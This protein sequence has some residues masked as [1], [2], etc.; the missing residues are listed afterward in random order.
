M[1]KTSV[2]IVN[3]SHLSIIPQQLEQSLFS[4]SLKKGFIVTNANYSTTGYVIPV[5]ALEKAFGPIKSAIVTTMHMLGR[6]IK[7]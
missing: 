7:N 2:E 3:P 1:P 4:P 5:Y 6:M